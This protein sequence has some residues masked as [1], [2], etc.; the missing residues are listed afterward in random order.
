MSRLIVVSNRVPPPAD[1]GASAGG[2]AVA[3]QAALRDRGGLWLGWSGET[4]A[5]EAESEEIKTRVEGNIT[6]SLVD[7]TKRDQEEYYSGFANR[8]LW[9]LLH[10]RLD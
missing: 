6:F 5:T 7:L 10:Y 8:A 3:L 4:A 1:K 9:P 2:L